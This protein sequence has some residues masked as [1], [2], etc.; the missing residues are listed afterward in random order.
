MAPKKFKIKANSLLAAGD[1]GGLHFPSIE[2]LLE[3]LVF[4]GQ[5]F[6]RAEQSRS[7]LPVGDGRAASDIYAGHP[8]ELLGSAWSSDCR[9][10]VS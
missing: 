9:R 8:E 4:C 1:G 10:I 3:W 6:S 5:H 2:S 7:D